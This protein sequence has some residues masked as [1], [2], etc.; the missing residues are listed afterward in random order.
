MMAPPQVVGVF[1]LATYV[2]MCKTFDS[3]FMTAPLWQVLF[4]FFI[5]FAPRISHCGCDSNGAARLLTVCHFVLEM[6]LVLHQSWGALLVGELVLLAI[7]PQPR[8]RT[9][10]FLQNAFLSGLFIGNY[11]GNR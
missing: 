5:S 1:V 10:S 6:G 3:F 8:P 4:P 2:G 7:C 11:V 9:P